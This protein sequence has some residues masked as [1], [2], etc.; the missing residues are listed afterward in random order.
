M[1]SLIYYI[2]MN[3][4]YKFTK[5]DNGNILL[6]KFTIDDQNNYYIKHLDDGNILLKKKNLMLLNNFNDI[7]KFDY[8]YSK[9]TKCVINNKNIEKYKFVHILTYIYNLIDDGF[10]IIKNTLI[11]IKTFE[12]NNNGFQYLKNIGISFQ[13]VDANKSV[14]EIVNQCISNDINI[15]LYITDK[16]NNNLLINI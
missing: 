9:I 10:N 8:C 1:C 12:K 2:K 13:Q 15:K 7:K 4:I 16:N 3:N 5:L 14:H 11:N 6:K